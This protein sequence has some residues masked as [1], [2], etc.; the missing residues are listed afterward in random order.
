M[1]SIACTPCNCTHSFM[2]TPKACCQHQLKASVR[3]ATRQ[4]QVAGA[5]SEP[6]LSPALQPLHRIGHRLQP[7]KLA[8]F[9]LQGNGVCVVV[10][11]CVCG[12]GGEGIVPA[13]LEREPTYVAHAGRQGG[14]AV[15][16]APACAGAPPAAVLPASLGGG[17]T[18]K[19]NSAGKSPDWVGRRQRW[20]Q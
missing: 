3:A 5:R 18:P 1:S 12:G 7:H 13:P 16:H 14:R 11:V 8:G 20:V 15:P 10:C 4:P 9:H 19:R 6:Q 17:A 2:Y